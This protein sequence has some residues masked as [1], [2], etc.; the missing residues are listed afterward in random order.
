MKLSGEYRIPAPRE[1][2]WEALNDPDV[3][4]ECI[5][6]CEEVT[7]TSDNSFEAK[8]KAKVGPVSA[9]FKG[10]VELTDL[11]PPES[12]TITGSGSGGAAGGAKGAAKVKLT[13]D[14]DETI[15]SYDV[16]ATVSGKLAQLGQRMID[17][18]AK[19]MANQF[20]ESFAGRLGGSAV[21]AQ[22]TAEEEE[23]ATA[24]GSPVG[25]G[26]V[27]PTATPSTAG[28]IPQWAWIAGLAAIVLILIYVFTG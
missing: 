3:L 24:A 17:P 13:P 25:A 5:P 19:K 10:N 16:D 12:Y 22:E 2:V 23:A 14:G 7:K 4:K 11:N 9:N 28:G 6:G 27:G 15:L 18:V 21:P 8:V 20:F 1:Q 26:A